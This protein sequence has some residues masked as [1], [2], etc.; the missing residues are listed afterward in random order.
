[1]TINELFNKCKNDL[2]KAD[3][4]S[5]K[6]EATQL[7]EHFC[8][9][10]KHQLLM[11]GDRKIDPMLEETLELAVARRIKGEPLQYIIGC[12]DFYGFTF[13]VGDGVLIP[14][15]DTE[16]LV[17]TGISLIKD[18]GNPT[19]ADLCSGS[20][21]IGI[22][23]AKNLPKSK[24]LAVELS[25]K[26][27]PYLKDNVKSLEINNLMVISNDV[28]TYCPECSMDLIVSNPPYVTQEEMEHLQKEVTF[29]PE[30]ALVAKENGLYF[31]RVISQRYYEFLNPNGWLAFEVGYKQ[32]EQVAGLMA[33][34][35]YKNIKTIKDLSGIQRVVIGQK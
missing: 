7:M 15:S 16:V 14:R 1:M 12:W 34:F 2:A 11:G 20:G 9:I 19:V 18:I 27:L 28:I 5:P 33:G 24:V 32:A 4:D 35:G 25:Q 17:D 29:E 26:A 10:T 6:F 31:Y 21:C 3:I 8:N 13:K 30:M 22:S 23:I